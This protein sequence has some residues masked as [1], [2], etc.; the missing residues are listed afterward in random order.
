[1]FHGW[2]AEQRSIAERL[3]LLLCQHGAEFRFH[4]Y[5]QKKA[6]QVRVG[7]KSKTGK[8]KRNPWLAILDCCDDGKVDLKLRVSRHSN[9]VGEG[10][11]FPL[12][13][14]KGAPDIDSEK[15]AGHRL[16]TSVFPLELPV[17]VEKAFEHCA[18]RYKVALTTT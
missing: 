17:W 15:D 13:P 10:K 8:G 9:L 5:K 16:L 3:R 2:S 1:M 18:G 11:N 14:S 7:W 4:D 6:Q 12:R